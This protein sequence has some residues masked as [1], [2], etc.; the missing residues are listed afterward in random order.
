MTKFLHNLIKVS[1][2][3][4]LVTGSSIAIASDE[5]GG[6]AAEKPARSGEELSKTC[7]ACHG[8]KGVSVSADFPNLAGQYPSYL[9]HAL[10]GYRSGERNNAIMQSFVKDMSDEE[11]ENLSTFYG[12]G[13]GLGT[14]PNED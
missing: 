1:A 14:L 13:D 9:L 12:S 10:K 3:V 8:A 11:L 6:H 5:A 2:I 7:S 4:A